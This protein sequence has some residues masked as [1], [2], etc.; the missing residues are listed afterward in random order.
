MEWVFNSLRGRPFN[1]Q[2]G[3][4]FLRPNYL[5]FY[6]PRQINFFFNFAQSF[7][8]FFDFVHVSMGQIVNNFI[9]FSLK[10][11][12]NLV[13]SLKIKTNYLFSKITL[14]PWILNGR[15]LMQEKYFL[16]IYVRWK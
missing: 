4:W 12:N 1:I 6:A 9:F 14:P 2:V 5:F 8:L 7:Y 3:V 16:D 13:F 11:N 15:P 10:I